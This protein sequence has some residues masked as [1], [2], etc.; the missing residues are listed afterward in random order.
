[1]SLF[2][3]HFAVFATGGGVEGQLVVDGNRSTNLQRSNPDSLHASGGELLHPPEP[4]ISNDA[5]FPSGGA[6]EV[7]VGLVIVGRVEVIEV[8]DGI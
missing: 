5:L 8:V 4:I 1:M 6:L 3:S 7:S 2:Q